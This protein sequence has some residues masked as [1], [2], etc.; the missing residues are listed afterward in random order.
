MKKPDA[1][2]AALLENPFGFKQYDDL[3]K[4]YESVH[5]LNEAQA[6]LELIE[7]RFPK[8]VTINRTNSDSGQPEPH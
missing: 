8:N 6:F 5:K 2:Y 1:L 4:Y 3:V 7:D